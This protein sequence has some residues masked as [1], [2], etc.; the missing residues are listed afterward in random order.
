M[1]P[2]AIGRY[3]LRES[4]G[5]GAMGQ[6]Y[7]AHD[8]QLRRDVAVKVVRADLTSPTASQR[9]QREALAWAQVV[10]PAVVQVL[11]SGVAELKSGTHVSY[12]VL[13]LV[14]GETLA[15]R[16]E[17][18]GP[19]P[20][21]TA[22]GIAAAL[23]DGLAAAHA[24][25]VLHRDLKP[26][27]VLLEGDRPKITDFG[28]AKLFQAHGQS[29]TAP[30][31]VVGTPA[32]MSPEQVRG[33]RLGPTSDVYGLGAVLYAMLSGKPPHTTKVLGALFDEIANHAPPALAKLNPSV[34]A[35]LNALV[36]RCLAK[37]PARRFPT[38]RALAVA[39]GN[40]RAAPAGG[41]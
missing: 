15:A 28:L 40:L 25:G 27:N 1:E 34:S 16:I 3:Q 24:A 8:P 7:L 22:V 31:D 5:A 33:E 35:P 26:S 38:A 20:E 21:A 29:L 18:D 23:A 10:H 11:D 19:L 36:A 17:R 37:D 6:V 32:Y 12:L 14:K 2:R 13:E 9:F 30:E 4:L 41:G 39:L